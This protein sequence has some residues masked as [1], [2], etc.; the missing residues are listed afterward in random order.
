MSLRPFTGRGEFIRSLQARSMDEPGAMERYRGANDNY[1]RTVAVAAKAAAGRFDEPTPE[2]LNWLVAGYVHARLA[3]DDDVRFE[4]EALPS[5]RSAPMGFM[6]GASRKEKALAGLPTV[7]ADLRDA[8]ASGDPDRIIQIEG[9]NAE[10]LAA[11]H[12]LRLDLAEES[13]ANLCQKLLV[14]DIG[15]AEKLLARFNG[16]PV[17]TPAPPEAATPLHSAKSKS[18]KRT[19]AA[20]AEEELERPS[21]DAGEATKEATRTA[22]RFFGELHGP[23]R[24]EEITRAHVKD[25]IDAL[26]NRPLVRGKESALPFRQLL[27]RYAEKDVPRIAFKTRDAHLSSLQSMWNRLQSA[28]QIDDARA[29]PFAKHKLGKPPVVRTKKDFTRDEVKAMFALPVF[30]TGQR[31]R[32]G[33]GEASYWIPLFLATT[34]ARPEEIAQLLVADL[35]RDQATD[36]WTLT[37]TD[38]GIHPHKGPRRLK[39]RNSYRTFPLPKILIDLGLPAYALWLRGRGEAVLFPELRTKGKRKL[40]FTSFGDWWRAYLRAHG[41]YPH[42]RR[43]GRDFRGTWATI[44]RE[45]GLARDVQEYVMGHSQGQSMNARYGD[46]RPLG[47]YIRA[48]SFDG[49]GL[50]T[51]LRWAVPVE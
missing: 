13:F 12:S 4:I 38:E 22:L 25:Y 18:T 2:H 5:F 9:Q 40:L 21:F 46:L 37:I 47:N 11:D 41:A 14:A 17:A 6:D 1:E 7:I 49:W 19:F 50:E 8:Y 27:A 32:G 36:E 30:T 26:T 43:G 33:K 31:P 48:L 34:G 51:V 24:P 23:L 35:E 42:Q 29:N 16:E 28:G 15:V 44:A 45:S 39:N 10:D 20:L 3:H